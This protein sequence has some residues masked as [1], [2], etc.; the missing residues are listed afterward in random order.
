MGSRQT[1][2][3]KRESPKRF[4]QFIN[5]LDEPVG[6][7]LIADSRVNCIILTGSHS[8]GAS[9][10]ASK[11]RPRSLCRN[12]RKKNAIIVTAM[13]DRDLAIKDIIHSAFGH[14]GQKMQ[15][16]QP[17]HSGSRNIR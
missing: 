4:L 8:N 10:Y 15:C 5:C 2:S 12:W 11:T 3:G 17:A 13:A 7:K 6:S 9:L 1:L 16:M 14:S